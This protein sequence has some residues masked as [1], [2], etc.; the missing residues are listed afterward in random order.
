MSDAIIAA[1]IT[2]I[3]A[4]F[5]GFY[6]GKSYERRKNTKMVQK[7]KDRA[8]QIQIGEIHNGEK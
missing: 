3:C 7:A 5:A 4:L 8:R 2:G 1:I 6:G